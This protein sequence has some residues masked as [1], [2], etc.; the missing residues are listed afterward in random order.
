MKQMARRLY[1]HYRP[2]IETNQDD[3]L[4]WERWK[5]SESIRRNIFF[6]NI[7]NI[8][9]ARAGKL[10]GVYFEPL[11]DVLVLNL[12]LPAPECMW[13]A[14]SLSEWLDAREHALRMSPPPLE[15]HMPRL[16][17]TLQEL[18]NE[19]A[20][21]RLDASALLPLTRVILASTKIAP[22]GVGL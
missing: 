6:A 19:E 13:R 14:C 9:G 15:G 21:G 11:D 17:Q 4:N 3:E 18:L 16:T 7:I 12:Y 2:A 10:N 1:Q 8:L 20:A 22:S 5:F